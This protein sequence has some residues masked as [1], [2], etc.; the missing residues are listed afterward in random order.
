MD[1][2]VLVG[3]MNRGAD[4][5]E[6]L[7]ALRSGQ[8]VLA[9][10][11][12]RRDAL[13]V[14]HDEVGRAVGACAAVE[15]PGDVGVLQVCQDLAL[16]AKVSEQVS[17]AKSRIYNFDRRAFFEFLIDT[18][19]PVDRSHASFANQL[20][21]PVVAGNFAHRRIRCVV[22]GGLVADGGMLPEFL[23]RCG[24]IG[25]EQLMELLE[26]GAVIS[27]CRVQ[28]LLSLLRSQPGRLVEK[29]A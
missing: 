10:V 25:C 13:N 3:V 18:H 22:L 14:L 7:Q 1:H 21:E 19:C 24:V 9:A 15:Q 28:E 23:V 11:V 8:V 12:V 29:I 6:E 2:H 5:A 17:R 20:D 27:A 26:Q 4:L 16:G